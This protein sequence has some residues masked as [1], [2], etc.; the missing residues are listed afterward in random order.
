MKVKEFSQSPIKTVKLTSETG[1]DRSITVGN[2]RTAA[3]SV[4]RA[5]GVSVAGDGGKMP[6]IVSQC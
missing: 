3:G 1:D 2:V 4:G 5:V 6:I